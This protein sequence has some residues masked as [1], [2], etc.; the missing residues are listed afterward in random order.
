MLHKSSCLQRNP[1]EFLIVCNKVI[2]QSYDHRCFRVL[3]INL[4]AIY[5][6]QGAVFYGLAQQ[7]YLVG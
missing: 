3:F 2:A 4:K 1:L 7:E 6:I 5:A